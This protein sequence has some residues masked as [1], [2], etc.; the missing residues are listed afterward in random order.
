MIKFLKKHNIL[1][2][3]LSNLTIYPVLIETYLPNHTNFPISQCI[4]TLMTM[5]WTYII[6]NLIFNHIILLSYNIYLQYDIYMQYIHYI[7]IC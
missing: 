6:I 4:G 5:H 1:S 3:I 2:F 7:Y